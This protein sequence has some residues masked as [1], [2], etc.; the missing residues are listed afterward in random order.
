MCV[1]NAGTAALET[2]IS[3]QTTVMTQGNDLW[4]SC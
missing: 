4:F 1:L 2:K 3:E